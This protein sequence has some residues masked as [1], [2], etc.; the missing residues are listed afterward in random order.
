VP[1][2]LVAPA[3]VL[4][5][6]AVASWRLERRLAADGRALAESAGRLATL[7]EAVAEL[8]G[9]VTDSSARHDGL[10]SR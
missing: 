5:V 6:V 9:Q 3:A 4:I 1:V 7:R 2:V 8:D 10:A